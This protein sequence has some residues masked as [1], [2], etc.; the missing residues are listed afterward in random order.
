MAKNSFA[1]I[2]TDPHFTATPTH[3]IPHD[4]ALS[5]T[6]TFA[7]VPILICVTLAVTCYTRI[8]ANCLFADGS[9]NLVWI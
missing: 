5:H 3:L 4:V 8:R 7:H 2:L 1:K 6:G 9:Y